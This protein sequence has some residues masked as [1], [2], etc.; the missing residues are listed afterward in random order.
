MKKLLSGLCVVIVLLIGFMFS[1][2]KETQ[3]MSDALTFQSVDL[4]K[5]ED[6]NY[7]GTCQTGL[8][9]VVVSVQVKDGRLRSIDLMTHE[10]GL[11]KEAEKITEQMLQQNRI[12]VD[13][14][15]GATISSRAIR[16]ACEA[17]LSFDQ[18]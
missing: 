9:K 15:S 7:M 12:D 5:I 17:A 11:G 10:H 18:G 2:M 4:S 6:G 13:E 3:E 1:K 16:K 14:I 8:V